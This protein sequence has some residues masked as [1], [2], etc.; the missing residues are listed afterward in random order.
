MGRINSSVPGQVAQLLAQ[1]ADV[2]IDAAV[3]GIQRTAQRDLG[4]LLAG[5]H[6]AGVAQQQFQDVEFHRG[7]I[8]RNIRCR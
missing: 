6:A 5:D 7:Q 3:E 1:A 2:N 4:N 8:D